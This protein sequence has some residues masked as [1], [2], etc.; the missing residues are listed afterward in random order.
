MNFFKLYHGVRKLLDA[1]LILCIQGG[2]ITILSENLIGL[3]ACSC[4]FSPIELVKNLIFMCFS[5]RKIFKVHNSTC[6]LHRKLCISTWKPWNV[7]GYQYTKK[8]HSK[9]STA[10]VHAVRPAAGAY[11]HNPTSCGIPS[12]AYPAYTQHKQQQ[13][14][15]HTLQRHTIQH[16]LH[17]AVK[18]ISTIFFKGSSTVSRMSYLFV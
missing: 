17:S 9:Y 18:R 7:G 12:S 10:A 8:G 11:Q 5:T 3:N 16:T 15:L 1:E 13:N 4:G 6:F 2:E 14:T